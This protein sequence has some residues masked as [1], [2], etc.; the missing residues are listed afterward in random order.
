VLQR[1]YKWSNLIEK[2][3]KY[4]RSY[5]SSIYTII[6]TRKDNSTPAFTQKLKF[7]RGWVKCGRDI[8]VECI[9]LYNLLNDLNVNV[10]V[11][12]FPFP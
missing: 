8:S 2:E 12:P 6:I 10:N 5:F 7:R 11:S 9:Q 1:I 3:Q 4:N